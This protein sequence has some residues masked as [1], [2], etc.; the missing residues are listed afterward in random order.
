MATT[1]MHAAAGG[2]S[3][4]F[5]SATARCCFEGLLAAASSREGAPPHE[6]GERSACPRHHD[7][8]APGSCACRSKFVFYLPKEGT[9]QQ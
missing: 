7:H 5:R 9:N 2:V 6:G 3:A 1:M 4:L 8:S